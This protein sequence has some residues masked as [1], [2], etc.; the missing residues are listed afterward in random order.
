L[1]Q[2]QNLIYDPG[3]GVTR[4]ARIALE[5]GG[6]TAMHDPTEGGLATG[7]FELAG[8]SGCGMEVHLE[9][10]PLIALAEKILPV[11]SIDPL[12][13]LASGSLIVCCRPEYAQA[14]LAAWSQAG[15]CGANIG[16]ITSSQGLILY[17]DG[18]QTPLPQFRT[19]EIT[20]A[21][22]V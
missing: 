8:A 13:A 11:F 12:G 5:T 20:K 21:F 22:S 18:K 17:R 6:V 9:H 2:A 19:D 3:I 10:I 14:I 7:L 1:K 15:I 16:T 4:D